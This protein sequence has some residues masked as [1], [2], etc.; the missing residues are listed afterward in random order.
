MNCMV[1]LGA[2]HHVVSTRLQ[3]LSVKQTGLQPAQILVLHYL[4]LAA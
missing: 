2:L 3:V 4:A 1:G